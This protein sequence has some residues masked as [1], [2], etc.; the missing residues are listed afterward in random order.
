MLSISIAILIYL[1]DKEIRFI[2]IGLLVFGFLMIYEFY[3]FKKKWIKSRL[4]SNV[5]NENVTMIFED[6]QMNLLQK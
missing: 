6:N 4:E 3:S 1:F 5:N 2:S